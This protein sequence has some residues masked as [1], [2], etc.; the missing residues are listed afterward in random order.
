MHASSLSV[1]VLF[2]GL[3]AATGGQIALSSFTPRIEDLPS[4]C[5]TVYNTPINGCVSSD[6]GAGATCSSGCLA[7]LA[8]IG[9]AVKIGCADVDVGET[10]MIGVFQNDIGVAS[11]CPNNELPSSS[12]SSSSSPTSRTTLQTSTRTSAPATTSASSTSTSISS[13]VSPSSSGLNIDTTA[14]ST[15]PGG[16][17]GATPTPAPTPSKSPNTGASSQL[18][19]SDSGGGSPFD[20]VATGAA[21]HSHTTMTTLS[22]LLAAVFIVAYI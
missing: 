12:S 18:S 20:V 2:A 22:T 11:L 8:K 10:S 16:E 15:P 1:A 7:G 13:S 19:N 4:K 6:F 17:I 21:P 3:A 5:K 9:S 14:T